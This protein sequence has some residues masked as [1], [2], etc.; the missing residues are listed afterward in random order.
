MG[1]VDYA[2]LAK[3]FGGTSAPAVSGDSY[4]G[5]ATFA[6]GAMQS[7]SETIEGVKRGIMKGVLSIPKSLLMAPYEVP[8]SVIRTATH[9]I[10]TAQS[11]GQ[12]A[13]DPEQG[14]AMIAQLGAG[15]IAP[16]LPL[17]KWRAPVLSGVKPAI[18]VVANGI[19]RGPVKA[20]AGAVRRWAETPPPEPP[21]AAPAAPVAPPAGPPPGPPA[22]P[23]AA[24]PM[25]PP[26]S[27][28]ERPP[29]APAP[30]VPS[31]APASPAAPTA[32][33]DA[34][35]ALMQEGLSESEAVQAVQ[36]MQKGMPS[37]VIW[38]RIQV[39]RKLQA[40]GSFAKLKSNAD[41][42]ARVTDRNATGRWPEEP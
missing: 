25:P 4:K 41:V 3:Q 2:A 8:A 40:S 32:A 36:W 18:G 26:T 37:P 12:A 16:R 11:L 13:M 10:Q 19:E 17:P 28:I 39:A 30:P 29:A 1:Q 21:P 35:Q 42:E 31:P 33:T 27:P 24:A 22:A 14:G 7:A 9:P 5:P 38:Q 23:A 15:L 6:A 34:V 20:V